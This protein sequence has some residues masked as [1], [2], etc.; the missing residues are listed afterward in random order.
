[1]EKDIFQR[2]TFYQL[3]LPEQRS[4]SRPKHGLRGGA[5]LEESIEVEASE[6]TVLSNIED[7][8]ETRMKYSF[9]Q[10]SILN[11]IFELGEEDFEPQ[12]MYTSYVYN[13]P[14]TPFKETLPGAIVINLGL[15]AMSWWLWNWLSTRFPGS[16]AKKL[17]TDKPI[18]VI[19]EDKGNQL[20][21]VSN[22]V[23]NILTAFHTKTIGCSHPLAGLSLKV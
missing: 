1:V 6:A 3:K 8:S 9:Q 18:S 14:R 15:V 4:K 20:A 10:P 21:T 2:T 5:S 12:Q 7:Y 16:N 19:I 13:V 17:D 11:P 23:L 22:S